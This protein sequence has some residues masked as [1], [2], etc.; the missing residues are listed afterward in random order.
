MARAIKETP[1]LKGKDTLRFIKRM[2]EK[3]VE[4]PEKRTRRLANY[5]LAMRIFVDK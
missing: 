3:R 1:I 2:N 5:Q 4:S